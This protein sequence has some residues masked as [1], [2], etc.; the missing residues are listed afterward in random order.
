MRQAELAKPFLASLE[1][2]IRLSSTASLA[3][4]RLLFELRVRYNAYWLNGKASVCRLQPYQLTA[5]RQD[6]HNSLDS[7]STRGHFWQ[8]VSSPKALS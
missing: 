2:F 4:W 3:D 6:R 8:A 5:W 1:F 7:P